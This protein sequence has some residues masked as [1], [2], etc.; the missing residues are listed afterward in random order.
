MFLPVYI[1]CLQYCK[2]IRQLIPAPITFSN[3]LPAFYQCFSQYIIITSNIVKFSASL[4]QL[5]PLST[6]VL[7]TV[8]PI[9][10]CYCNIVKLSVSFTPTPLTSSTKVLPEVYQ[11]F[12]QYKLIA[13]NAI[14]RSLSFTPTSA[15]TFYHCSTNILKVF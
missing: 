1:C 11:C 3:V 6:D 7:P 9:Y 13:S 15:Q 8:L 4:P 12:S 5:P 14:N 2:I 10:I